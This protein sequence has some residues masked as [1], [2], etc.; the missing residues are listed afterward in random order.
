MTH[1][2]H[3]RY[4]AE[5]AIHPHA[6][7]NVQATDAPTHTATPTPKIAATTAR[8]AEGPSRPRRLMSSSLASSTVDCRASSQH[9]R[10]EHLYIRADRQLETWC[11]TACS[12]PSRMPGPRVRLKPHFSTADR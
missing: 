8:A 5:P 9:G 7:A 3:P 6:G 1:H 12:R 2:V 4:T 11:H 10:H